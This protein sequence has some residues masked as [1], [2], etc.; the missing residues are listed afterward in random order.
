MTGIGQVRRP[1]PESAHALTREAETGSSTSPGTISTRNGLD[2]QWFSP[3]WLASFHFQFEL[4]YCPVATTSARAG[5]APV[6]LF[7]SSRVT[8][9]VHQLRRVEP[10]VIATSPSWTR[11]PD[12]KPVKALVR[13]VLTVKNPAVGLVTS[14]RSCPVSLT[15]S[16]P[17]GLAGGVAKPVAFS[18]IDVRV[19]LMRE[20]D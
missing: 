7:P 10:V 20:T 12:P 18:P 5:V 1:S 2:P 17:V 19:R 16:G 13:G 15:Y 8:P 9:M 3:L 4:A 6:K 14:Q 11:L